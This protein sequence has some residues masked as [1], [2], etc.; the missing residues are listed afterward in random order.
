MKAIR[1]LNDALGFN[2]GSRRFTVSTVGVIPKIIQFTREKRQENLAISLHA[3]E[4]VLRTSLLPIAKIY[5]LTQLI[6]AC[7]QYVIETGRRI[8]FEWAMIKGINDS[9]RDAHMLV[10]LLQGI[11]C[12]VNIIPLNFVNNYPG[13]P[14]SNIQMEIFKNILVKNGVPCTI[15]LHR[16]IDIGAGCGQLFSKN[17]NVL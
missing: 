5:P 6:N 10:H 12:H 9:E 1:I 7:R 2:F 4:N 8:S 15:R 3:A 13:E 17:G 14:S 16:G 11:N